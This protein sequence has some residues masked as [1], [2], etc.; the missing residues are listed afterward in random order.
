MNLTPGQSH[1]AY[2]GPPSEPIKVSDFLDTAQEL[3]EGS[4]GSPIPVFAQ[5][6]AALS[7]DIRT[8]WTSLPEAERE[9]IQLEC[10]VDNL[11]NELE[12]T[13]CNPQ[14]MAYTKRVHDAAVH[15]IYETAETTRKKR[16]RTTVA[17]PE[18]EVPETTAL[19]LKHEAI[20]LKCWPLTIVAASF[21]RPPRQPDHNTL[22]DVKKLSA[23]QAKDNDALLFITVYNRLSW[24]QKFLLRASQHVLLSSQSLG[25]L[26]DA[27]PCTSKEIPDE[28]LDEASVF[29]GYKVPGSEDSMALDGGFGAAFCIEGV[30]YAD[31]VDY[32]EYRLTIQ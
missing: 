25:E 9:K 31:A 27:I 2:I 7:A 20:R 24:G 32:A 4:E 28:T 16:K 23:S 1:E 15:A 14:L 30:L 12:D 3:E 13:I 5:S 17:D 8:L 18:S 26:F 29:I 11:R 19:R 21:I 10:R 6:S 22:I